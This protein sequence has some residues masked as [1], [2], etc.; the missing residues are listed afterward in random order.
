MSEERYPEFTQGTRPDPGL[1]QEPGRR[2]EV[3]GPGLP[4][5]ID[6]EGLSV[7]SEARERH[8]VKGPD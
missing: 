3:H 6:D 7:G 8:L 2:N 1:D 4:T 5:C